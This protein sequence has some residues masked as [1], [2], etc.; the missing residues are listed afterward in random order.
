MSHK[1]VQSVYIPVSYVAIHFQII[2]CKVTVLLTEKERVREKKHD[3]KYIWNR[4]HFA[5][6]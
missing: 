2:Q 1:T 4:V 3:N 6:F 5:C